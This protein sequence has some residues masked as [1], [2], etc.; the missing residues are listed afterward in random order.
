MVDIKQVKK[1]VRRLR[2]L[3]SVAGMNRAVL[4]FAEGLWQYSYQEGYASGARDGRLAGF[5][6]SQ[7]FTV[8]EEFE[9]KR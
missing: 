9:P 1:L 8:T 4:E 6:E 7:L 5:N 2:R 3:K